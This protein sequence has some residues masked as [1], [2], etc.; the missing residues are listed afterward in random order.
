L[1]SNGGIFTKTTISL[2][3][4][5]TKLTELIGGIY[6]QTP[7][8]IGTIQL[9]RWRSVTVQKTSGGF[10]ISSWVLHLL[11]LSKHAHTNEITKTT[12][13][14]EDGQ[15]LDSANGSKGWSQLYTPAFR[16]IVRLV[17]VDWA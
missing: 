14:K 16:P 10:I 13:L 9:F 17:P 4:G 3:L 12:S 15:R 7:R 6:S 1:Q 5:D 8:V 2:H 11:W